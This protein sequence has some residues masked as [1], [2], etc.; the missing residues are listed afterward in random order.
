VVEAPVAVA[1]FPA[2]LTGPPRKWAERYYNLQQWS[3][4]PAGGHFAAMEE[5]DAL[6]A[7]MRTFFRDRR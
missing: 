5:P 1:M 4:M 3:V 7:D 6:V 2:E